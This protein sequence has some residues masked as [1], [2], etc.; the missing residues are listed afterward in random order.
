M[1]GEKAMGCSLSSREST[2]EASREKPRGADPKLSPDLGVN[3]GPDGRDRGR[4]SQFDPAIDKERKLIS[5]LRWNLLVFVQT[6]L[7]IW[8]NG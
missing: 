1:D 3:T 8:P 2:H 7:N 5:N 4:A 6:V